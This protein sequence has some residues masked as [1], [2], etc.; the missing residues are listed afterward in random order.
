[1]KALLNELRRM[2]KTILISSHILSELA[3]FC[4]S[5]GIIERGK[6]LAAGSIQTIQQQI[7]THRVIKVR[8]LDDSTDRAVELL[9]DDPAIRL[10]E[11]YDRTVTAEFEGVDQDMAR[12]LGRLVGSGLAVHSFAEE[13]LSLEEVFMMITKGIVS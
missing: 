1:M 12:I 6:L 7:R 5:I 13:P 11:S 10:V 2:G 3:D 9:R 8:L 4:T